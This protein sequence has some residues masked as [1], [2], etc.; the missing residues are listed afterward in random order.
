MRYQRVRNAGVLIGAGL[1]GI[2]NG[3]VLSAHNIPVV[4]WLGTLAGVLVL[5]SALRGPGPLPAL[6]T[7]LGYMLVGWGAYSF[8]EGLV[9]HHL[10]ELHHAGDAYYD[11]V[12]LIVSGALVLLG[13][14][15][16]DG[17]DRVPAHGAERR[18][19]RERRLVY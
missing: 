7:L 19:G 5:W 4:T 16:R 9:S 3:V 10:L 8:I 1:G 14:A 13:L 18:S 11:W 17:R 15:L 2:L 12:Y 6:R